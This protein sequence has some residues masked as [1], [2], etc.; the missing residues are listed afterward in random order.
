MLTQLYFCGRVSFVLAL[1]AFVGAGVLWG[2]AE[3]QGGT[4]F[5]A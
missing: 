5:V 1:F 4:F 3:L 2:Q